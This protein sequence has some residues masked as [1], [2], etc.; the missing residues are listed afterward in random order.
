VEL[1]ESEVDEL[2]P[3]AVRN[4][5][6]VSKNSIAFFI[7]NTFLVLINYAHSTMFSKFFQIFS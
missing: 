6:D 1:E 3:Q 7:E 5:L 4:K 2:F